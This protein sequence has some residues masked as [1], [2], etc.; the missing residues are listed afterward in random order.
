M[1]PMPQRA[2]ETVTRALE[3]HYYTDPEIYAREHEAIFFRTWHY[4]CHVSE[5]AETGSYVAFEI[6]GQGLFTLRDG[7]GE[8]RTFY[9]V[10]KHRAHEMVSGRGRKRLLVCPYHAW[11]YDLDGRLRKAPNA[12][13]VPGFDASAICLTPVK[14]EVFCG[15]VFVNLDPEAAPMGEWFPEAEAQ[16]KAFRPGIETLKPVKQVEVIEDCNWKVSVENYSECYHCK[17]AHPTFSQGVIDPESYNILP[18]GHCLRHTTNAAPQEAMTYAIGGNGE[19]G[20]SED[21]GAGDGA[22]ANE[23]EWAYSSWFLWP[24]W[25]FQVYPGGVLNTYLWRPLG[26]DRTLVVR[27]WYTEDGEPSET[28]EQLAEQDRVT[29]VAEDVKLVNSVQRGLMNR[30]YQAG[31]LVIDPATGVNSEHSI[32]AIHTWVREALEPGGG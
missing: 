16:L 27:G 3:P 19:D 13:K 4:A 9:N 11:A 12:D 14:T 22:A 5:V 6:A 28:I 23:A 2:N 21:G 25:S 17:L 24:G 29:T 10:C 26:V 30:G 15:F 20:S 31:P 7:A 8:I 18:Q 32:Q 1:T